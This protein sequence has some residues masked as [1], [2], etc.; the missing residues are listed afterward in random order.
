[1]SETFSFLR[2]R[3]KRYRAQA[4]EIRAKAEWYPSEIRASFFRIAEYWEQLAAEAE[5]KGEK[6][7]AATVQKCRPPE[8][9]QTAENGVASEPAGKSQNAPPA[10]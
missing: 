9:P 7:V 2:G 6:D 5:A 1:L 10:S 3:A 4:N 8:S